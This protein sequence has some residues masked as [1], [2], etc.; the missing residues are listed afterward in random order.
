M[1]RRPLA[2]GHSAG[3]VRG[4]FRPR[5]YASTKSSFPLNLRLAVLKRP[6]PVVDSVDARAKGGAGFIHAVIGVIDALAEPAFE[7]QY[8]T[9][10]QADR[11]EQ[12][13]KRLLN[14][15]E[16]RCCEPSTRERAG[17]RRHVLDFMFRRHHPA[18]MSWQ[19]AFHD[20]FVPEFRDLPVKVQDEV[21]TVGRRSI[22]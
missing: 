14:K 19:A 20:E 17:E 16:I 5:I 2:P 22:R 6:K 4:S 10:H 11:G 3:A 21:Y 8:A 15:V 18:A 13:N 12:D 7:T 9:P 1:Q